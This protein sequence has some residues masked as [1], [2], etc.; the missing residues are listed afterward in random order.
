[1]CNTYHFLTFAE[2]LTVKLNYQFVFV[3]FTF[4][5][6]NRELA[7]SSDLGVKFDTACNLTQKK[8]ETLHLPGDGRL[9]AGRRVAL[10]VVDH[11]AVDHVLVHLHLLAELE[12]RPELPLVRVA[13]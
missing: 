7:G 9:Y 8:A 12:Q 2:I 6:S 11:H 5:S 3:L 4:R 13:F 10:L 1:M